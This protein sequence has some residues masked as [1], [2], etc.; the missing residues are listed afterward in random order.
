MKSNGAPT[1]T[2][3]IPALNEEGA[4][5]QTIERCLDAQSEIRERGNVAEVQIIV[6]SDGSTD[7]TAEIAQKYAETNECVK[8][9]VFEQNRGYGAA[10]KEGFRSGDGALVAFLDADGTCDPRF[11]GKLCATL[12]AESADIA[13]G[14]RMGPQSEMP[15]VRRLGNRFFAFLLGFL[16]GEAVTDTASGMRVLRREA[17]RDLYPLPDRLDF[18]PAMSARAVMQ[19]LRIIEVPMPYSERVGESKLHAIRDGF[20]FLKTIIDAVLFHSPSRFFTLG[21][22]LCA[23]LLLILAVS[24]LEFYLHNG[25]VEDWMIYRFIACLLLGTVGFALLCSA[26]IADELFFLANR[27]RPWRSFGNQVLHKIF[28]KGVLLACAFLA[29][30]SSIVLVWPGILEYLTTRH[31]TLHWSRVIVSAFGFIIATQCVVTASLLRMVSLWKEYLAEAP[32]DE[33]ENGLAS[34]RNRVVNARSH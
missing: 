1:L 17:L 6:V 2:I 11:F 3:V 14:D 22:G 4:I 10:I 7:R 33:R 19:R 13:L 5:G 25:F 23:V 28:S 32:V 21:F 34:A 20:R 29:I 31:V 27:R 15:R 24:P 18:T 12:Q 26:V 30:V 9:I 8:L 16:S